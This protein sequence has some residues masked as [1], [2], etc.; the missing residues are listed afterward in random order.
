[1][2]ATQVDKSTQI[3]GVKLKSLV[4]EYNRIL[5]SFC[6][7]T[8]NVLE[9]LE[10]ACGSPEAFFPHFLSLSRDKLMRLRNV[11]QKTI[12]E[13][14]SIQDSLK[15]Y[16][17]SDEKFNSCDFKESQEIPDVLI[18]AI[19]SLQPIVQKLILKYPVR[20]QNVIRWLLTD[21]G[22]DIYNLYLFITSNKF[23]PSRVNNIGKTT[24][25]DFK[26]SIEE[27]KYVVKNTIYK[28]YDSALR[29]QSIRPFYNLGLSEEQ[30]DDLFREKETLGF[31]PIFKAVQMMLDML[32][33]EQRKIISYTLRIYNDN[34]MRSTTKEIA[35]IFEQS[36]ERIRQKR[37]N[38]L[39]K[40]SCWIKTLEVAV[41]QEI[42]P[43]SYIMN[44]A[45]RDIHYKEG[46][47]YTLSFI[48][49]VF[50]LVYND[51][52]I[53]G[54]YTKAL[55]RA[56]TRGLIAVPYHLTDFFDYDG[57]VA[58]ID[59]LATQVRTDVEEVKIKDLIN[60]HLKK[61]YVDE[62]IKDIEISCRSI[63]YLHYNLEV[64]YINVIFKPNAYKPLLN[65]IEDIIKASPK[66]LSAEEIISEIIDQYPDRNTDELRLSNLVRLNQDIVYFWKNPLYEDDDN[67]Y[68]GYATKNY[69]ES[70]LRVTLRKG[71]SRPAEVTIKLI[72]KFITEKGR[73]PTS[74]RN[75]AD[76]Y[77][78]DLA[79]ALAY[80]RKIKEAGQISP[81]AEL[82]LTQL[83]ER[84]RHL[85]IK[86][87]NRRNWDEIVQRCI[88]F[89]TGVTSELGEGDKAWMFCQIGK[90]YSPDLSEQ[91][92]QKLQI[93][94][95]AIQSQQQNDDK[96]Y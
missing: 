95:N 73:Y 74:H 38:L 69:G 81:S 17:S 91:K 8:N 23:N 47:D 6:V 14:I 55:T 46:T 35:S 26:R 4:E 34:Q 63:L 83:D 84:F 87:K 33:E 86:G 90:F 48:Y 68:Y 57:F 18:S 76:N 42:C 32:D 75:K 40:L 49:W 85:M 39:E 96:D 29:A 44:D 64:D 51:V 52:A 53:V 27:I 62:Y 70:F 60:G 50:S 12:N 13:L 30:I 22:G 9:T 67:Q 7:R 58:Q 16:L 45:S 37:N 56:N 92:S 93:L 66:P 15:N 24:I 36:Y 79:R 21:H 41:G 78:Y 25:E 10:E 19:N 72:E 71:Q 20:V 94:L 3:L 89:Y 65:I 1:M 5:L 28:G 82:M 77:E 54:D 11:G 59:E 2:H 31:F 80:Q 61:E 43:Y 88:D